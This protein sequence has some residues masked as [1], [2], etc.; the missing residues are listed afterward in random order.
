MIIVYIRIR[1][2]RQDC[3]RFRRYDLIEQNLSSLEMFLDVVSE[4][5]LSNNELRKDLV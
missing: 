2:S 4:L 3:R 1:F 5:T